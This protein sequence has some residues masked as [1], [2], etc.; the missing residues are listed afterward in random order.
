[1]VILKVYTLLPCREKSKLK[2]IKG[3]MEQ[4]KKGRED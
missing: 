1:M 4:V 2:R 3:R